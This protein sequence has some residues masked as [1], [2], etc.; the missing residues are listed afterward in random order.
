MRVLIVN[1]CEKTGGAAVAANR[2]ME[3]LKNNGIKAKML[4][5]DKE[6]DQITVASLNQSPLL[7]INGISCGSDGAF[8]VIFTSHAIIFSRLILP[9]PG[10]TSR[11]FVSFRRQM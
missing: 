1:T 7:R 10:L 11:L 9:I 6:T 3:A 8:S 5:R 2:L 4:V